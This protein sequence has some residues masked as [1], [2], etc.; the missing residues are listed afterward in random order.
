MFATREANAGQKDTENELCGNK[1]LNIEGDPKKK[2]KHGHYLACGNIRLRYLISARLT[3]SNCI[4][5]ILGSA[6]QFLYSTGS[7]FPH[8]PKAAK[9][10]RERTRRFTLTTPTFNGSLCAATSRAMSFYL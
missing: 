10:K 1:K 5:R 3:R 7:G 9:K 8:L 2:E 4:C 6:H